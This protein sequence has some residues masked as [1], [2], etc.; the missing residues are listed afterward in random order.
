VDLLLTCCRTFPGRIAPI[1][2]PRGTMIDPR[3]T[4]AVGVDFGRTAEDYA[5]YRAGFPKELYD[6]LSA[7][8][9][10]RSGQR[11]LDLG[12]GT[13]TLARG[14]AHRGATVVG[15]DP[16]EPLLVE[17]RRLS[18][19]DGVEVEYQVGRAE[20]IDA[21]DGAFDVVTAGQC[22]HWF[23]R[24]AA[25]AECMRVL[26]ASGAL[27]ICHFDWLPLPGNVVA[28]TEALIL[29]HN[30]HWPLAG[31]LGMYPLWTLDVAEAGFIGLE[32]FSFDVRVP[33]SH[34]AWRGRIRASAGVAASLPPDAVAVF[35]AELA[36]LLDADFATEPMAVPHRVWAL[37]ARVPATT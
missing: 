29:E 34:A 31:G 1:A 2:G 3:E 8:G 30:P 13:G 26:R 11:L 28:A 18:R 6:R 5:A 4:R 12:T 32:T 10:G 25:A 23:D 16:A 14:F 17:A 22:W 9:I 21:P 7:V 35:D 15:I 37:V 20:V 36:A 33:Y 27:V 24:P 19:S